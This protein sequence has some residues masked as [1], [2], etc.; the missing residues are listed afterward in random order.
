M[1]PDLKCSQINKKTSEAALTFVR[2]L[3]LLKFTKK[4][5]SE[6]LMESKNLK[7]QFT[8]FRVPNL[9]ESYFQ[10]ERLVPE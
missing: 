3:V 2:F 6:L 1:T 9:C 10:N 7:G 5:K 4:P 8:P